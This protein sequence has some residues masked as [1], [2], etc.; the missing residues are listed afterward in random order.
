MESRGC[1]GQLS[2]QKQQ[3]PAQRKRERAGKAHV[4]LDLKN[5]EGS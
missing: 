2:S 5:E 3:C 4:R 1:D